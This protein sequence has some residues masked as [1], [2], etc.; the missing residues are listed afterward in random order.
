QRKE[1]FTTEATIAVLRGASSKRQLSAEEQALLASQV[2]VVELAKLKAEISDQIVKQQQLYDIT[3]KSLK[4]VNEM[5]ATTDQLNGSRGLSTRE[6]ER[7]AELAKITTDYINSGGGEGD[8]KL[9]N[10]IKAK[11]DRSE[12][13]RAG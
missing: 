2:R 8:E 6:M 12:E 9:Q 3:D 11:N 7:Q 1:L 4:F 13:Q 5:T 10:M